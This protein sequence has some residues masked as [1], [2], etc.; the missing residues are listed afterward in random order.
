M[1]GFYEFIEDCSEVSEVKDI[2]S[3]VYP[4]PTNGITKI[5][6]KN[7][8]TISIFNILGE[9]IFDAVVTGDS[10]EYDFSN[11]EAGVYFLKVETTSGV[12]T[13]RVVL[14]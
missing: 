6:A 11:H 13:K 4:N 3:A 5:E 9:M 8:Q 10:F 14:I 1:V 12:E 7:L 2:I